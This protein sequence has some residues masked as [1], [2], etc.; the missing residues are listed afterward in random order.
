MCWKALMHAVVVVASSRS[1]GHFIFKDAQGLEAL[2]ET[3]VGSVVLMA[4]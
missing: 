2:K 1:N 3:R 4:I